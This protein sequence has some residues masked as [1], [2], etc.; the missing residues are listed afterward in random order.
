MFIFSSRRRHTICA[1][2]TGVR[3]CALPIYCEKPIA[4][5]V[6]EAG[7]MLAAVKKHGRP[8]QIGQWQRSQ[9]HFADAVAFV[10]SGQLGNIRLVKAWDYQG[11]SE[12]RRVGQES[13][14]RCRTRGSQ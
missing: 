12:E 11:R 10:R 4:N 5:S 14:S 2:L 6:Q 13:V 3:S 9:Q 1:L 8:V 7:I